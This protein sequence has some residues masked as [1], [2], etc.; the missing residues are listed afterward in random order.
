MYENVIRFL[1]Q[2][3]LNTRVKQIRNPQKE[4]SGGFFMI[5]FFLK[6]VGLHSHTFDANIRLFKDFIENFIEIEVKLKRT[7]KDDFIEL[8]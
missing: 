5:N 4:I 3:T 2:N 7:S 6:R 8:H 1:N